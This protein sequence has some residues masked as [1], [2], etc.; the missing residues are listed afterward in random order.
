MPLLLPA[1]WVL[2]VLAQHECAMAL[3]KAH[4]AA[5]RP[6]QQR[7][8]AGWWTLARAGSTR[9][10][11]LTP[12]AAS[13]P[14]AS[15]RPSA[16]SSSELQQG[17]LPHWRR[18]WGSPS[19]PTHNALLWHECLRCV[20]PCMRAVRSQDDSWLASRQPLS[21]SFCAPVA[22][23]AGCHTGART[24]PTPAPR[25]AGNPSLLLLAAASNT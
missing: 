10:G 23:P 1:H 24:W 15:R 5:V 12:S 3:L 11:R 2:C 4:T 16:P 20:L 21:P 8:A 18:Q 6:C 19:L 13:T 14:R 17:G 9:S 25:W 7:R 22:A